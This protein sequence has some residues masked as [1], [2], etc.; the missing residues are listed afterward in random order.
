MANQSRSV[1]SNK[2]IPFKKSR[3]QNQASIQFP[4]KNYFRLDFPQLS[5]CKCSAKRRQQLESAKLTSQRSLNLFTTQPSFHFFSGFWTKIPELQH[6][7]TLKRWDSWSRIPV[8]SLYMFACNIN[9]LPLIYS[10]CNQQH[11]CCLFID[12]VSFT[13]IKA[14][15]WLVE[16]Q[17]DW[18][19]SRC[20][21]LTSFD[22]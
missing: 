3:R 9:Q 14:A 1:S 8:Q 12:T 18:L 10:Y 11:H 22:A 21:R 17:C 13:F 20:L 6:W 5:C 4:A 16:M 19:R 2:Y 7:E 15:I